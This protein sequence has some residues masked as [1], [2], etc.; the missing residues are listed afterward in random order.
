MPFYPY[1]LFHPKDSFLY[2][3]RGEVNTWET[4]NRSYEEFVTGVTQAYNAGHQYNKFYSDYVTRY[5][6]ENLTGGTTGSIYVTGGTANSADSTLVFTNTSGTSFTVTNSALLFND[7]Y[8]SGGTLNAS[9]GVVTF[10]NTTGGTFEV[11]GFDGFTSY[12]SAN[13][14]GSISPSGLT[15]NVGIGT[16]TPS[17]LFE[18]KN[19]ISFNP[20][21]LTTRIGYNAGQNWEDTSDGNTMVGHAAG[22]TGTWNA[23]GNNTAMGYNAATFLSK[24]DNN[25]AIGSTASGT[26]STG[27][28]NTLLG[29]VAG[30]SLST[31]SKNTAIGSGSHYYPYLG[32]DA[33]TDGLN[34]A[35]GYRSLHYPNRGYKNVAIGAESLFGSS[36]SDIGNQ[37]AVAV[38]YK[39]LN[40][41]RTGD[42]NIAIGY[43]AADNITTGDNNISIG[44]DADPPSATASYQMNIGGIIHGQDAYTDGAI[45]QVGIGTTSPLTKLDVHHNP[46]RLDTDTGGGEVVTFGTNGSGMVAGKLYYLHTDGAWTLTQA[47]DVATGGSQ[48]LGIALGTGVSD[49][50]LLS[51]YFRTSKF[52]GTPDEGLPVYVCETTAG[53]VN[54]DTPT[55][56]G[57]YVRIVGYCTN[58]ANVIYFN[59]DKTWVELS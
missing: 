46:N 27:S 18:V 48:L 42:Y 4:P 17:S 12:W 32:T 24:G 59:P 43:Q 33:G 5:F 54:I 29:Y 16:S 3:V 41:S 39:A 20:D 21:D 52:T 49:G 23:A 40:A 14:D 57:D 51:G 50:V 47:D 45:S 38:G 6:E 8:V 26:L 7:A 22:G 10:I 15:T 44:K 37:G 30:Y 56:S 28:D 2:S 25:T 9:T 53:N 55:T 19:Y 34:T 36:S 35:V 58:N 13:T 1:Y 11:S 31:D